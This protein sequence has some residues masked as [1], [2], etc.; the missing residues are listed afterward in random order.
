MDMLGFT[1]ECDNQLSPTKRWVVI[2]PNNNPIASGILLAEAQGEVERAA[3]GNQCGGRT[4]L[5]LETSDFDKQYTF[6]KQNGVT[7]LEEP[8]DEV[9]G[10]VV[11]W[12]DPFGNKWDLIQHK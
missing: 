11:I 12:Q 5:F 1:L 6:M 9:Y 3:I 7:F 4:W 10:K 8:R 2:K